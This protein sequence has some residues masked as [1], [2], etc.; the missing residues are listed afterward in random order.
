MNSP[1]LKPKVSVLLLTYNHEQFVAQAIESALSQ[2]TNFNYEIVIGE[3]CSTDGTRQMV[4]EFQR[5]HPEKIRLLLPV[6]NL[7]MQ[8]NYFQTLEACSGQY[9]SVL[10]GDDFWTSSHKLQKQADYLDAHR[11]RVSCFHNVMRFSEEGAVPSSPQCPAGQKELVTLEDLLAT[12]LIPTC[13]TMFRNTGNNQI[14]EWLA[15]VKFLDWA[16]HLLAARRGNIGYINETMAA[17]RIHSNG[18]YSSLPPIKNQMYR[19]EMFEVLTGRLGSAHEEKLAEMIFFLRYNLAIAFAQNHDNEN[20]TKF[21]K[22]CL[23]ERPLSRHCG[24]KIRLA[25]RFKA[26][27]LFSVARSLWVRRQVIAENGG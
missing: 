2:E 16:L 6:Q 13:S 8:R 19:L 18:A 23:E 15:S 17:Y 11:D 21:M 3:D 10:E 14:P 7:G 26:P 27:R 20:A 25:L 4:R 5:Q 12:N 1:P 24:Q 9:V 22:L